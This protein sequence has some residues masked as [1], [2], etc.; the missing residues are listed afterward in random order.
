MQSFIEMTERE[1]ET[2]NSEELILRII[3]G[4]YKTVEVANKTDEEITKKRFF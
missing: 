1:P 3:K 4:K 2:L